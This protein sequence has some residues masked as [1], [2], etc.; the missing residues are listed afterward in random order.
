VADAED[1]VQ[2]AWLRW[3]LA[4]RSAIERPAAWLTTVTSRLC[5]DRI[6][7]TSRRREQYVG[8]WLPEPISTE[9]GPEALGEMAESLTVGFL[10]MLDRLTAAERLVF[11]LAEVFGE[12]YRTIAD[13]TGRSEASCRQLAHRARERVRASP[14]QAPV[15]PSVVREEDEALVVQLLVAV[16]SGD[17]D[18]TVS[19]LAD[20][21]VL[22]S[23]GGP[24][25]RAARRP[26]TTPPRVARLLVNLA[27]RT[28]AT[29]SLV[30]CRLN[31]LPSLVM[32]PGEEV[33]TALS[34]DVVDGHVR[35]IWVVR[36]PDKLSH[37]GE[38]IG[39][40]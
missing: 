12:P 17:I 16:S 35:R 33:D 39:L 14:D 23:D 34:F 28:E 10:V 25:R 21:V 22:V 11:L 20:D 36:A 9:R 15:R 6:R 24:H 3:Q 38:H 19:L 30:P 5:L 8:P 4:D 13:V 7:S 18:A 2:E 31:G 37:I 1:V 40:V 29:W 32:G 26:V 27:K